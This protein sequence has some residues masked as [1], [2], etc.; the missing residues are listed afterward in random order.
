M[1]Q[2]GDDPWKNIAQR[3][4][5]NARIKGHVSN[6]TDY[7]C[8][9]EIEP[10]VEGLVHMSEM[11]WTNKNIHPSKVV[12]AGQEIDIIV[13]DINE[14]RRRISLGIKQCQQNPWEEFASKHEVGSKVKGTIRSMTDFGIFIGLDGAIDGLVHLSDLSWT[15]AGEDAV[16]RYNKGDEVEAV[17]LAIDA[18]RERI[19]LG[20]KQLE[21]DPLE[22]FLGKKGSEEIEATVLEV[23]PKSASLDLG[24]DKK[25]ILHISEYQHEKTENLQDELKA[26]DKITVKVTNLDRKSG[27]IYVSRKILM[28][29][30]R[31][32]IERVNADS[33]NAASGSTLGDL[34]KQQMDDK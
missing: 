23:T 34:L 5:V 11:D 8:F 17:V 1:K 9:V 19:S 29:T 24:D 20:V 33:A 21:A 14:D 6:V 13:L 18:D 28:A 26:G 22:E 25:G 32:Q 16:R 7:G 3:Y 2:L 15:E 31:E 12:K 10:G 27:D 30:T 4:P